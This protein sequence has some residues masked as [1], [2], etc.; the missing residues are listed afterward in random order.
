MLEDLV[1]QFLPQL[2]K[3]LAFLIIFIS[4]YEVIKITGGRPTNEK[5]QWISKTRSL[6]KICVGGGFL[7][8]IVEPILED[9]ILSFLNQFVEFTLPIAFL[10]GGVALLKFD[11]EMKGD[12]SKYGYW[13]IFI[14]ISC[15]LYIILCVP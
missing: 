2:A 8:L 10:L 9:I 3:V 7:L 12:Y 11:K 6:I 13:C 4:S 14:G 15:L 5:G 1:Q